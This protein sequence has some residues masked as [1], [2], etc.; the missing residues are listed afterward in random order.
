MNEELNALIAKAT[1]VRERIEAELRSWQA[2][3][4]IADEWIETGKRLR[5][6]VEEV[7]AILV[8]SLEE[9]TDILREIQRV[10]DDDGADW[11][12]SGGEG[13]DD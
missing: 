5:A 10:R 7:G 11:W 1:A 12:K 4:P 3:G 2:F 13:G 6:N 8:K 9:Q